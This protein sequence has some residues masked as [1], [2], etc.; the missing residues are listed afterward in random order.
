MKKIFLLL[1]LFGIGCQ[2]E[3]DE[4]VYAQELAHNWALRREIPHK[5]VACDLTGWGN[6]GCDIIMADNSLLPLICFV[7]STPHCERIM[8]KK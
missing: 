6:Y 2:S 4:Q 1:F 7:G 8:G 3:K 5:S